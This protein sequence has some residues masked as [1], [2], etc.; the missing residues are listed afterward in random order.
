MPSYIGA[1][2]TFSLMKNLN[3]EKVFRTIVLE[4]PVSRAEISRLTGLNKVTVSNCVKDLLATGLVDEE[5]VVSADNGRPPTMLMLSK[6]FG[7]IIGMEISA[8]ATMVVITD[9]RGQIV[10]KPVTDPRVYSPK[11]CL[12][13]LDEMVRY[14][15]EKYADTTAGVVGI[16]LAMPMN[17]NQLQM[18]DDRP[19]LPDWKNVDAYEMLNEH[20]EDIPVEVLSTCAAGAIGEVHFGDA[21]INASLAYLHSSMKLKMDIYQ[22]EET[23][24]SYGSFMGRLGH[25]MMNTGDGKYEQLDNFAS[26][27]YIVDSLYD[28]KTS[29]YDAA[30]DII[31][32]AKYNDPEVEAAVDR[33]L[34]Y[35]A[36]AI[37]NVVE[38]FNPATI[39]LAGFLGQIID[40]GFLDKLCS[41][42][43]KLAAPG[44]PVRERL[45]CSKL[46][47]FGVA[48]GCISWIR[49]N[50][51]SYQFE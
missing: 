51:I 26:M 14:C 20:F 22:G 27:K 25:V 13:Y 23:F 11:E 50:M 18:P 34:E 39:C 21:D 44:Y 35:L 15:R 46:G 4:A 33:M 6:S 1:S 42:V 5:G 30:L 49:D 3:L 37:Y 24:S 29:P 16:G 40:R 10:E 31:R 38:L 47:L 17:Y 36:V 2:G 7:V 19:A 48:F 28:D 12:D 8:M 32:R 41:K 45:I 9:L 43:E